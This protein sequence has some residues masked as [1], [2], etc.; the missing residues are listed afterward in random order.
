[1]NVKFAITISWLVSISYFSPG[2]ESA[3]DFMDKSLDELGA[4]PV[5]TIATGT[6][7]PI[8]QSAE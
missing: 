1:M 5:T 8:F 2:T 7:K 6:S 3:E 4:I